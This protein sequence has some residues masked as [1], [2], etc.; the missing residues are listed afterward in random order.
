VGATVGI[1]CGCVILASCREGV[2]DP[3]GPV[4]EAERVILGDTTAIMLA[5]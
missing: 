3:R 4:G 2:V 5:V 1:L